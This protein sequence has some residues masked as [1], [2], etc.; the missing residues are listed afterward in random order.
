MIRAIAAIDDKRGL[1][2]P[3]HP[4]YNVPWYIP[5]D[6]AEFKSKTL[7]STVVMG[8]STYDTLQKPLPNRRN[9]VASR[10]NQ[11]LRPGFELIT[12]LPGFLKDAEG[13]I[14]VIGGGEI[15]KTALPYCDELHITHVKG[16]F[17][18]DVFFPEYEPDFELVGS[19]PEQHSNGYDFNFAV[20]KQ[21]I[22]RRALRG[23][24]PVLPS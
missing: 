16:D 9:V 14:W 21:I 8:R 2:A 23:D 20:Y 6:L 19:T 13:D 12:D 10:V 22:N 1:A 3:N 7:N 24:P 5:E 17:G 4:P 11:V 18:C 15:Y